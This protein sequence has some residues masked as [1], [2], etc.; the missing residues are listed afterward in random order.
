MITIKS[1][2]ELFFGQAKVGYV[3]MAIDTITNRPSERTYELK[4]IDTCFKIEQEEIPTYNEATSNYEKKTAMV[5]VPIARKERYVIYN[6]D[7]IEGLA[8]VL[9][10][11]RSDFDGE[12]KYINELFRQGLL[13]ITKKECQDSLSGIVGKGMYLS[14]VQDWEIEN[15]DNN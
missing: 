9:N 11:K 14:E 5:E 7:T 3:R 12:I 1:N 6:Y 2:K 4:I 10:L 15:Y 13:L 8:K